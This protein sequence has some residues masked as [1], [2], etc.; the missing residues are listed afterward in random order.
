M[1]CKLYKNHLQVNVTQTIDQQKKI[2]LTDF[3]RKDK[4]ITR[5]TYISI[6]LIHIYIY[7]YIYLYI[8]NTKQDCD[9]ST[10]TVQM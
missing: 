10:K 1:L 9:P 5:Y 3:S 2:V 7:I 8:Y 4:A 6:Y